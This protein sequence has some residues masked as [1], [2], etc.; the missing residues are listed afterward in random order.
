[1]WVDLLNVYIAMDKY[2][3]LLKFIA[4]MNSNTSLNCNEYLIMI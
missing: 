2:V 3:F 1:M 4:A